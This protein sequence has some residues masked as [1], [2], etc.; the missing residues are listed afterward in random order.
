[1]KGV[2]SITH[3]HLG[4]GLV[5]KLS[6]S[7]IVAKDAIRPVSSLAHPESGAVPYPALSIIFNNLVTHA[8]A[9]P[10]SHKKLARVS[11]L[12]SCMRRLERCLKVNH[13]MFVATLRKLINKLDKL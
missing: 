10:G 1:M 8:P 5:D 7:L 13:P 6:Y 11:P 3:S 12:S 2:L 9:Q 4:S